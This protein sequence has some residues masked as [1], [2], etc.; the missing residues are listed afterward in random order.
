MS[1][2][3][4]PDEHINDIRYENNFLDGKEVPTISEFNELLIRI[5]EEFQNDLKDLHG[6]AVRGEGIEEWGIRE[7][8]ITFSGDIRW[9]WRDV[10]D[11]VGVEDP[12][13]RRVIKDIHSAFA[14]KMGFEAEDV[15]VIVTTYPFQWKNGYT[16]ATRE[17]DHLVRCG[18]SAAEALDLWRT[19]YGPWGGLTPSF[20]AEKRGVSTQ[21]VEKNVRMAREKFRNGIPKSDLQ[22]PT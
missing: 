19:A 10:F 13:T 12:K 4:F 1:E 2:Y 11:K 14:E 3:L 22:H 18:L 6:A 16:A 5:D 7:R 17:I 9:R 20:W 21:A 8:W 15:E